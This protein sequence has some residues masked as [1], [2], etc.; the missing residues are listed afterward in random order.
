MTSLDKINGECLSVPGLRFWGARFRPGRFSII[1]Q[2]ELGA[3]ELWQQKLPEKA[4]LIMQEDS[5]G[6]VEIHSPTPK[7]LW[8]GED[9]DKPTITD[10][11]VLNGDCWS[12]GSSLIYDELFLPLIKTGR[13]REILQGIAHEHRSQFG[14]FLSR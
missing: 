10:C 13:S 3:V 8:P 9:D 12:D 2:N 11:H 14:D 5:Y 1:A 4:A 7:F 6:G